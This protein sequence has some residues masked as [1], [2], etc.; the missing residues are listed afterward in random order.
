MKTSLLSSNNGASADAEMHE[1]TDDVKEEDL[2]VD[3]DSGEGIEYNGEEEAEDESTDAELSEYESVVT[4]G[5]V[6]P[7]AEEHVAVVTDD[8]D[9]DDQGMKE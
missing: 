1:G 4:G 5:M 6:A 9:E 3:T 2:N 7:G 8:D